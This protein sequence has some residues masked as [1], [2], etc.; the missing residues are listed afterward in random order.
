MTSRKAHQARMNQLRE[1]G[2]VHLKSMTC[3]LCGEPLKHNNTLADTIWLQCLTPQS[4]NPAN[5]C[6]WQV[7]FNRDAY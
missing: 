1:E 4:L 3:P 6:G 2:L 5:G 7:L